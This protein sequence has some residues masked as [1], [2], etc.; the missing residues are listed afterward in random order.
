MDGF[1]ERR[2]CITF[3]SKNIMTVCWTEGCYYFEGEV[4]DSYQTED[5]TMLIV[6][7]QNGRTREV[8]REYE[9]LIELDV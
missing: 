2:N 6:K 1:Y 9:H 3:K 4:T 8:L 5:G 7:V